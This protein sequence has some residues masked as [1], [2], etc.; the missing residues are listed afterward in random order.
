M[1][2]RRWPVRVSRGE[3]GVV[4]GVLRRRTAPQRLVLRAECILQAA[5]GH[6]NHVVSER[7]G[8]SPN[9]VSVWCRRWRQARGTLEAAESEDPATLQACVEEILDDVRRSGAPPTFSPE[10]AVQIAAI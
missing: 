4:E 10:Q 1:A 3:K 7:I 8:L 9:Q 5:Q 6:P 2:W